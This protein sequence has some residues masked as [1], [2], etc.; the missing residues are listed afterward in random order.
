MAVIPQVSL[1]LIILHNP[2]TAI[3]LQL[4]NDYWVDLLT[5]CCGIELILQR[6]MEPLADAVSLYILYRK[7]TCHVISARL[8]IIYFRTSA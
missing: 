7:C 5:K 1:L 8:N 4:L 2:Q 6:L 3:P